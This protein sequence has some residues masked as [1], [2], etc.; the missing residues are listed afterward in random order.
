M[1]NIGFLLLYNQN[2]IN[3]TSQFRVAQKSYLLYNSKRQII[4][5]NVCW[6][7]LQEYTE[8]ISFSK[9]F[10]TLG[11]IKMVV[12]QIRFIQDYCF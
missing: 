5:Q 4:R 8:T 3:F 6:Y 12:M 9:E 2:K 11:N 7:N 1:T 10:H